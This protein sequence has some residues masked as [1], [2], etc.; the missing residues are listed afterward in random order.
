LTH[1]TGG[2]TADANILISTKKRPRRH[3]KR[4]I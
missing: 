3:Q 2:A 4:V 1:G